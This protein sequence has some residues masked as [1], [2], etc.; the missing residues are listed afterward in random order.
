MLVIFWSRLSLFSL[1]FSA[2]SFVGL[3]W[4]LP[5]CICWDCWAQPIR[6]VVLIFCS[7]GC[8]QEIFQRS[9][10]TCKFCSKIPSVAPIFFFPTRWMSGESLSSKR[11]NSDPEEPLPKRPKLEEKNL[12][13]ESNQ[14]NNN[15][16]TKIA[17]TMKTSLSNSGKSGPKKLTVSFKGTIFGSFCF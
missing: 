2:V 4:R 8:N 3:S 14:D 6:A 13:R 16:P 1:S 12:K 17:K 15:R 5:M 7:P 11:K 9:K 10:F